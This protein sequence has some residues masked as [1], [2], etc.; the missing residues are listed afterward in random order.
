MEDSISLQSDLTTL[1]LGADRWR[2]T[3]NLS[4][5]EVMR[6]THNKDKSTTRYQVS[7]TELRIVSNYKDLGVIMA[8]DT[9]WTKHVEETL[10]KVLGW[11]KRTI[12]SKNKDIFSILYKSLVRSILEYASPVWLPHQAKDI[13]EIEKVQRRASRIALG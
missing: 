6:I 5:C 8:R 12:G 4:K 2:V 1:D 10:H 11:L 13:H 3:C 9:S 7:G